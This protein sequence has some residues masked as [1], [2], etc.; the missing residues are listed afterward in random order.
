MMRVCFT[1]PIA[2]GKSLASITIHRYFGV[3]LIKMDFIG[4]YLLKQESVIEKVVS[5]LGKDVLTNGMLDRARIADKVFSDKR[6]L[7]AY[8]DL[9]HPIMA[10]YAEKLILHFQNLEFETVI[11]EAAILYEA[12]WQYLCDD[13]WSFLSSTKAICKRLGVE[14]FVSW[15]RPRRKYQHSDEFFKKNSDVVVCNNSTVED[16]TILVLNTWRQ[17]YFSIA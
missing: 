8:N 17:R 5:I 11:L 6:L 14:K 7:K 15:Y 13:V 2:S 12:N 10:A 9:L 1:G 3:P 16:F 4:H